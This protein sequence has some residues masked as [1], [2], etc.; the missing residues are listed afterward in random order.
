MSKL[1]I[2][3]N[4]ERQNKEPLEVDY[5]VETL[6]DLETLK[7]KKTTYEGQQAYCVETSTLYI[8]NKDGKFEPVGNGSVVDVIEKDN[9]NPISSKGV[10]NGL[11]VEK[12]QTVIDTPAY[13][14]V[15]QSTDTGALNVVLTVSDASTEIALNDINTQTTPEDLSTLTG[16]GT[17]YVKHIAEV[18]HEETYDEEKYMLKDNTYDKETIDNKIVQ[19]STGLEAMTTDEWNTYFNNLI[20]TAKTI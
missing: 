18:N 10:Y 2:P 11:Y 12:T 3:F 6:T 7:S 1:I 15:C 9:T 4:F 5:K 13:Y 19:A 20:I 17:E 14:S 16:D 8:Y